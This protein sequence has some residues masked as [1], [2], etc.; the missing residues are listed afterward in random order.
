MSRVFAALGTSEINKTPPPAGAA[1]AAPVVRGVDPAAA[2]AAVAD[3]LGE[4]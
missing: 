4:M 1:P 3:L 2:H